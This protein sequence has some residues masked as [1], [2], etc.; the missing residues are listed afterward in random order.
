M[1]RNKS[2]TTPEDPGRRCFI[3]RFSRVAALSAVVGGGAWLWRDPTGPRSFTPQEGRESIATLGDFQIPGTQG[4]LA[5]ARGTDRQKTLA[6]ALTALGGMKRFVQS[7]DRVLLKVNAAF[8]ASAELGATTHPELAAALVTAC[9][10]AGA[11]EVSVTDN[12][13]HDPAG[14]FLLTGIQGAVEKAGG[15]V[16]LPAEPLFTPLSLPGGRLI[17]QW[18]VLG[19]PF[20]GITKVIGVAPVKDH[21]R[22]GAS[23]TLKNWYGLLGGRRNVFHQDIH[24]IISELG[25]LLRP[26]LVVLDGTVS[27]MTNGPTGGSLADLKSTATLIAG[28]DSVA[29]DACGAELLG[30]SAADLPYLRKAEAAG[31]GRVDF[32]ALQPLEVQ[33][34]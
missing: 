27:M 5:I 10:A 30:R 29:V 34:G 20:A 28:T 8:A 3:K 2:S 26:T 23:L 21:H 17:R 19:G 11:A 16:I 31:V 13:I 6:A 9:R 32:R 12:P 4:K 15:R 22:S 7:G 25:Q 1:T 14:A 18:P 33:T 24:T